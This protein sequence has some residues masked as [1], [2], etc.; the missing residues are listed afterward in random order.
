[1]HLLSQLGKPNH[2][3]NNREFRGPCQHEIIFRADASANAFATRL[4][5]RPLS[6]QTSELQFY[7]RTQSTQG[8]SVR[9]GHL[10]SSGYDVSL[11]R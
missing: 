9:K 7:A 11:T 4:F 10:W 8:R 5:T 3:V 6:N 1:M 2:S